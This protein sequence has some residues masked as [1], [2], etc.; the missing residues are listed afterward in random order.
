MSGLWSVPEYERRHPPALPS[1]WIIL[2]VYVVIQALGAAITIITWGARPMDSGDFLIRL[3]VLPVSLTCGLCGLFYA[4]YARDGNLARLWNYLGEATTAE[5]RKWAQERVAIVACTTLTPEPELAE[6]MLGLEGPRPENARKRLSLPQ[7]SADAAITR[8]EEVLTGLLAPMAGTIAQTVMSGHLDVCLQSNTQADLAELRQ[9]WPRLGLTDN[10]HF[11]WVSLDGNVSLT[12]PWWTADYRQPDA[13]LTLGCQ[14]HPES[15]APAWSEMAVALLT[16]TPARLAERYRQPLKPLA[17]L[18]RSITAEA[19]RASEALAML[20]RA[21]QAPRDRLKQIWLSGLAKPL[22]H[23]AATAVKDS[24]LDSP[25]HV[26]DEAVGDV[27][28]VGALLVQALA[29]Q[30]V[31]HGQG[32]QL[33]AAH[34]PSQAP[35]IGLEWNLVGVELAQIDEVRYEGMPIYNLPLCLGLTGFAAGLLWGAD[36]LGVKSPTFFWTMLG[37]LI[38]LPFLLTAGSWIR[39]QMLMDEFFAARE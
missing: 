18:F 27:G 13:R 35:A 33:V 16:T 30:M 24:E 6:R 34:A 9:L 11:S 21:E 14:L 4:G 12:T 8:L 29:A 10:A 25:V 37:V 17:Y 3:L 1:L 22:R 20:L 15:E 26:L 39:D 31:Q 7:P 28:P 19:D 32:V 23:A 2:G 38:A 5:R 36:T